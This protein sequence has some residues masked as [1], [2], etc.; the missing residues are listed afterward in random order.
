MNSSLSPAAVVWESPSLYENLSTIYCKELHPTSVYL[1]WRRTLQQQHWE[2][3]RWHR[4][5]DYTWKKIHLSMTLDRTGKQQWDQVVTIYSTTGG[6]H[7][8][9]SY[10]QESGI[11]RRLATV[12]T[13]SSTTYQSSFLLK[14]MEMNG[15]PLMR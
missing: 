4:L 7:Q 15:K 3:C 11:W 8:R 1:H 10:F 9:T 12:S 5:G 13:S 14:K 2:S 6:Q